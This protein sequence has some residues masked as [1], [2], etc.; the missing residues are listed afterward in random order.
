M[1]VHW[2][3]DLLRGLLRLPCRCLADIA[4]VSLL[5]LAG[6][7]MQPGDRLTAPPTLPAAK[8]NECS[9][10]CQQCCSVADCPE[11]Y[12]KCDATTHTCQTDYNCDLYACMTSSSNPNLVCKK[13]NPNCAV[14]VGVLHWC[15]RRTLR[16]PVDSLRLGPYPRPRS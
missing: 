15:V 1:Q 14:R 5:L 2:R 9:G 4:G 8:P 13:S 12:T 10:V 11:G 3:K 16:D 6:R 7:R